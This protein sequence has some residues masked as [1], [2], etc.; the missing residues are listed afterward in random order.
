MSRSKIGSRHRGAADARVPARRNAGLIL[1]R[2]NSMSLATPMSRV[3]SET[4]AATHE[5]IKIL[6][7]APNRQ[8]G[9]NAMR[10]RWLRL[11]SSDWRKLGRA[12]ANCGWTT[13][14]G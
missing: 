6:A 4:R 5:N 13:L 14:K 9:T 3:R 2:R 1:D 12:I 7:P 10:S 8:G 11:A